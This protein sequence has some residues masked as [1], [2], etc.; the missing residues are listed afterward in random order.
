M[1]K[2]MYECLGDSRGTPGKRE[3]KQ[4]RLNANQ[5]KRNERKSSL[6]STDTGAPLQTK[7]KK[8]KKATEGGPA[9]RDYLAGAAH[10]KY[11]PL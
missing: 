3:G 10:C 8:K 6:L 9:A 1:P 2:K 4:P 11:Q 5:R 7:K